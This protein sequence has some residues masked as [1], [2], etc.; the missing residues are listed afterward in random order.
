MESVY[1]LG[2]V[3]TMKDLASSVWSKATQGADAYKGKLSEI[4]GGIEKYESSWK[5]IK[6]GG[7]M[8][9]AGAGMLAFSKS[10]INASREAGVL[11][12]NLKSL[13]ISESS[14]N[15]IDTAAIDLSGSMG[16]AREDVL[17]AAYDIKSGIETIDDDSIGAFAAS[18]TNA[19]IATKGSTPEMANLFVTLY[20]QN[21]KL[22]AG[23][24]DQNFGKLISNNVAQATQLYKI[25]ASS[26]SQA[27]EST[28]AS[29]ASAGYD[30]AEQF[31]VLGML[32]T[33]L[34]K[35]GDAGTSFKAFTSKA[36]QA[37]SKLGMSFVDINGKLLPV[38]DIM[39]KLQ[40]KY[41]E[42]LDGIEKDELTKAFGSDEAVAMIDAIWDKT[43]KL[44]ENIQAMRN[45]EGTE[46]VDKMAAANLDNID[47]SIK[48]AT[49]SWQNLKS[50]FGGGM[51]SSIK[52][53]V[54]LLGT[55]LSKLAGW[56]AEHPKIMKFVGGFVAI[57][58][59]V[60]TLVGTIIAAKGAMG[61]Y[62]LSQIAAT[63]AAGAGSVGF[64]ALAASVWAVAWPILAVI[65]VIALIVAA[66]KYW[67]T[68]SEKWTVVWASIKNVF[69]SVWNS[70]KNVFFSVWNALKG[71]FTAAWNFIKSAFVT[72]FNIIKQVIL[73]QA[74]IFFWPVY[75]IYKYWDKILP[76]FKK[77]GAGIK[78]SFSGMGAIL[79]SVF[80]D[81]FISAYNWGVS[82]FGKITGLF[83]KVTAV[84][85]KVKSFKLFGK[86]DDDNNKDFSNESIMNRQ[87]GVSNKQNNFSSNLKKVDVNKNT[88][89]RIDSVVKNMSVKNKKKID[90]AAIE[91]ELQ[92]EVER[93]EA[94]DD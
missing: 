21:K 41:G 59:V 78:S 72:G 20:N 13:G 11:Q 92:K 7:G 30:I 62:T 76:Y 51:S 54:D 68:I 91:R 24:S 84:W 88:N 52:P 47:T 89:V 60:T 55:G 27:I 25:E 34:G 71:G 77:I 75:L 29:A 33:T 10:M 46:F 14:I 83:K 16:I 82:I 56:G 70:I 86:D 35:G 87:L 69:S 53:F 40:R 61:L 79:K 93:A 74:K 39:E 26:L 28:K 45:A 36:Y 90:M 12:S 64:G 81:P 18:V 31:N 57:G 94:V 22:Y 5:K 85:S 50:V 8:A 23:L 44:N 2:A 73:I 66:W 1:T 80:V 6:I 4:E 32:T 43:G 42:T 15:K 49:Y 19:A 48:S 58:G 9:A 3:L 63:G 37:S 65:G 67:D 38:T 17:S